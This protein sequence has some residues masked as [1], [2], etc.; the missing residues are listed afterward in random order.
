MTIMARPLRI[1]KMGG[2]YHATARGNGRKIKGS[3][4]R[5]HGQAAKRC[6]PN[7]FLFQV[8]SN[9]TD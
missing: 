3:P 1:Q 2:W 7:F 9:R 8:G 5:A 6:R 4:I